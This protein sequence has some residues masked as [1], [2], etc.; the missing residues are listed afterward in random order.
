MIMKRENVMSD[1]VKLSYKI[2]LEAEDVSRSRIA[3]YA[4]NMKCILGNHRNPYINCAVVDDESDLDDYVLRLFV[5]ETV[6][7]DVCANKE[8]AEAFV[9]DMAELVTELAEAN[10]FLDMEGSFS[11]SYR[12]E[13]LAYAYTS[14]SG[15]AGCDFQ[16]MEDTE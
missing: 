12:G 5:D 16:L 10:S 11:I 13:T 15:D 3:S 2:F 4:A 6:E 9:D 7:E 8:M 1:A 14:A